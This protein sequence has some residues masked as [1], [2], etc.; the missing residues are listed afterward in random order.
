M[1]LSFYLFYANR[2]ERSSPVAL[3]VK[4]LTAGSRDKR[5]EFDPWAGPTPLAEGVATLSSILAWKSHGQR[6]LVGY[7]S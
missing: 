1:C 4:N 5:H 2:L 3:V 7:S 6:S